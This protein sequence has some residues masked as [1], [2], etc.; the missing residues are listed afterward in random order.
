M[1]GRLTISVAAAVSALTAG[2]V[3]GVAS[4]LHATAPQ[5]PVTVV[6]HVAATPGQAAGTG[7]VET[8]TASPVVVIT[9]PPSSVAAPSSVAPQPARTSAPRAATA[10]AAPSA[11][12]STP[13]PTP[14]QYPDPGWRCGQGGNPSCDPG[15]SACSTPQPTPTLPPCT[16]SYEPNCKP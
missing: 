9:L 8:V 13:A 16:Y 1:N 5:A 6:K 3:Y 11:A 12:P 7:A 15:C 14:T 4:S 10:P 2:T